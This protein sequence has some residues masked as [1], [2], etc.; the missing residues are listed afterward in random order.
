MNITVYV[1]KT[2]PFSQQL[3]KDLKVSNAS[4]VVKEVDK[5]PIA[6]GEMAT[7]SKKAVTPVI[8]IN[9]KNEDRVIIG[10]TDRIREGIKKII[11]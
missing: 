2:C 7:H 9:H 10:Y 5:D 6:A 4:Y 11:K 1:S 3:V 8:V